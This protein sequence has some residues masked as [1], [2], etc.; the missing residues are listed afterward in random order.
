MPAAPHT[1]NAGRDRFRF[2][3]CFARA[4]AD[5]PCP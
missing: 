5:L 4:M 3:A 1:G 2:E